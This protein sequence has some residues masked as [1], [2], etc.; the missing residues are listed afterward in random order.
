MKYLTKILALTLLVSLSVVWAKGN[1]A[2][3]KAY[4]AV[5]VEDVLNMRD[6]VTY[7]FPAGCSDN[8]AGNDAAA[9]I[10]M[11]VADEGIVT[12]M[13]LTG[14][15]T[16]SENYSNEMILYFGSDLGGLLGFYIGSDPSWDAYEASFD[17]S[18]Y[19]A[20][21][22]LADNWY[23]VIQDAYDDG[24]GM[25]CDFSMAVDAAAI[26][27]GCTDPS[28]ANYNPD[29]NVDD[30]SCE[31]DEC[32]DTEVFANYYE[33]SWASENS[34]EITTAAGEILV[35]GAGGGGNLSF[36]LCLTDGIY[37]ANLYDSYG[38]GWNGGLLT[39][40]FAGDTLSYTIED[41]SEAVFT[42]TVGT[43]ED[44]LGCTDPDATNYNPDATVDDGSCIYPEC[45]FEEDLN[46]PND[47]TTTAT[48]IL[49][50]ESIA[51]WICPA[52]DLDYFVFE[53][54]SADELPIF[55]L[56]PATMGEY[57]ADT[58]IMILDAAGEVIAYDEDAGEGYMSMVSFMD[59][60]AL[61]TYYMVVDNSPTYAPDDIMD[62]YATVYYYVPPPCEEDAFE[63][64]DTKDFAFDHGADGTFTYALCSSD[65]FGGGIMQPSGVEAI[66][67]SV[68]TLPAFTGLTA[69]THGLGDEGNDIDLFLEDY[70]GDGICAWGGGDDLAGS[71]N[72]DCEE[73]FVYHNLT[74]AAVTVYV[75]AIYYGGEDPIAYELTLATALLDCIDS[76]QNVTA[77]GSC[78]Q[79]A[80]DWDAPL[81]GKSISNQPIDI[82]PAKGSIVNQIDERP[83]IDGAKYYERLQAS[84]T[85]DKP[86]VKHT[87]MNSRNAYILT[88][89]G[90]SWDGEIS[91]DI[92]AVD[93]TLLYSGAAGTF[94]VELDFGD[95]IF[96]GYDSYGDGWNGGTAELSDAGGQV[97]FSFG[98]TSGGYF[99]ENF[100]LVDAVYGCMDPDAVN[101]NPDATV[102]DGSCYYDGDDCSVAIDVVLGE[103]SADGNDEWFTYTALAECYLE[104][105]SQ[106][107]TGDAAWDTNLYL[108]A[109]DCETVLASNDDCCGYWGPSTAGL[110]VAAGDVVLISWANSYNPGPFTFTVTEGPACQDD[111]LE[112]NDWIDA[113]T[114]A[115]LPY[116]ADLMLC[117]GDQDWFAVTVEPF[118]ILSATLVDYDGTALMD[119]GIYCPDIDAGYFLDYVADANDLAVSF[120]YD[121]EGFGTALTFYVGVR[122]YYG[123]AEGPYGITISTETY[124]P[125][126]YNVYRDD[127]EFAMGLVYTEYLDVVDANATH[128]YFVRAVH[129]GV[130]SDPLCDVVVTATAEC[131]IDPVCN[132]AA[133]VLDADVTLT[134]GYGADCETAIF[135]EG[136]DGCALPDGW[137]SYTLS[138]AGWLFGE[139][140]SSSYWPIP[141]G[142][143]C[144]AY[145]NDDEAND[146]GSMDYLWTGD[147]DVSGAAAP[148]LMIDS[149]FTGAYGQVATVEVLSDYD[150]DAGGY[151]NY[152]AFTVEVDAEGW[153]T[154]TY[155]LAVHAGFADMIIQFHSNDAGAWASGW[156]LDNVVVAEGGT[157][158]FALTGF[159]IYLD[160]EIAGSVAADARA[161]TNAPGW[162]TFF[163]EVAAV[164][165]GDVES[166]AVGIEVTLENPCVATGDI[167][168]DGS[169]NV[170]DVV[171]AVAFA[172]ET[173]IPTDDEFCQADMNADGTVNVLDVVQI[174]GIALEGKLTAESATAVEIG[175]SSTQMVIRANGAV[176]GIQFTTDNVDALPNGGIVYKGENQAMILDV[177]NG[178]LMDNKIT[179]TDA[180]SIDDVI[181]ADINGNQVD[182]TIV[183]IP[184]EY[185]LN[186]NYPNPFNPNTNI[187]YGIPE[188]GMVSL[189]IY[190]M[191]GQEVCTLVNTE[192]VASYYT[193]TWDGTN[194]FGEKVTSGVYMYRIVAGDF[195]E[196][197]KM[198]LL[199]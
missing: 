62:Y 37:Y 167:N 10:S 61:G 83:T 64:D 102:D 108:V 116:A 44:I 129:D 16:V 4:D 105:S 182:V 151:W 191:L 183:A 72:L 28:A 73:A 9:Q 181:V 185:S 197:A 142:D 168:A 69:S 136:F 149:Y 86:F 190:N 153:A 162:G 178:Y 122:D 139:D 164:F 18:A 24:G 111:E 173:M 20:G 11:A 118:S 2:I 23:V 152:T 158:D 54:T 148:V 49:A 145:S 100:Q 165:T 26:V 189:L 186:Q 120:D 166:D 124:T 121:G 51:G 13:V 90:G 91:W 35:S 97:Y 7:T 14:F 8:N 76:P 119:L 99:A 88:V 195:S 1:P 96:E 193:V 117:A 143:G 5:P 132:L 38:D 27:P 58:Y 103:N 92:L 160:G 175:L 31:Y 71:G 144:Y 53:H 84:I 192:Q 43:T 41:G 141:A 60:L 70:A 109:D 15:Y 134:W 46:E 75:G 199:K 22:M 6:V 30:G 188:D 77:T 12:S 33:G 194:S 140:G 147:I 29:A 56:T 114:L 180:M 163:Y 25:G 128:S 157:R 179:L 45:W 63:D 125:T 123:E 156:A 155:D 115:T 95:Y 87:D 74:D 81:V 89:G 34:F 112:E 150:A 127:V 187:K 65:N 184:D 59:G 104:V 67:W 50:G 169:V 57:A 19:Y 176:G 94:D 68:V 48:A 135:A 17:L 137:G 170:L 161:F 131:P 40:A 39:V 82:A 172:L 138:A 80:L 107:E 32:L 154:W 93:S 159:N 171:K 78:E 133:D 52:T 126:S 85:V 196:T 47:T 146:D 130:E 98:L 113:P 66:D 174:V 3:T 177:E 55:E 198:V 106:N 36:T 110:V 42:F 79:I 21:W 101:Y